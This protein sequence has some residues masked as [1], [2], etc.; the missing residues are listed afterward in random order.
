[1]SFEEELELCCVAKLLFLDCF[2]LV[3]GKQSLTSLIGNC[4][5]LPFGTQRRPRSFFFSLQIRNRGHRGAFVSE[6]TLQSC[7][8]SI[9]SFL[10]YSSVLKG[11]GAGQEENTVLDR[12]VN[13]KPGGGTQF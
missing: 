8:V 6:R 12:E 1:M 11:T 13:Y 9:I 7:L 2:L 3:T 10:C 5:N 4:L